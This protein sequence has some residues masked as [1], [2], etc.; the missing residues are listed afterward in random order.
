MLMVVCWGD[1]CVVDVGGCCY[2]VMVFG[3]FVNLCGNVVFWVGEEYVWWI[4][5]FVIVGVVLCN[6]L[7]V[8]D[9]VV[10]VLYDSVVR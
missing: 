2:D 9:S 6:V 5:I 3:V 10:V 1:Y 8:V 7:W 4:V